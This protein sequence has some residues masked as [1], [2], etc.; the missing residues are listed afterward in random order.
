MRLNLK[1]R[2]VMLVFVLAMGIQA[3]AG[4]ILGWGSQVVDSAWLAQ[5]NHIAISAGGLH[6][7]A[8]RS[9]GSIVGWGWNGYGQATPPPGNNYIAIS[10][11]W[12]HSLALRSDGR[13]VGWGDNDYGQATPPTGNNFIAISA[14]WDHSLALRSD[15]RIVGWGNNAYG[16]ATPADRQ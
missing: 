16:R 1:I 11:K 15:G 7:L 14:G 2:L 4:S 9:D 6:S 10:T 5:K 8:L 12:V 13:I 3:Q